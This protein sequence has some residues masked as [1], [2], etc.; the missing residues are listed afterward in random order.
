MKPRSPCCARS[1][2]RIQAC[3]MRERFASTWRRW[4]R[5][6]GKRHP[7]RKQN[8]EDRVTVRRTLLRIL[9][10]ILRH[11][12][13]PMLVAALLFPG[14]LRADDPVFGRVSMKL[15]FLLSGQ[16]APGSVILFPPDEVDAW[17]RTRVPDRFPGIR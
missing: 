15:N 9:R 5:Q 10:R 14:T 3:P 17:V 8:R 4:H 16:A 6:R 7:P 11:A 2:T 12:P 1:W 13:L